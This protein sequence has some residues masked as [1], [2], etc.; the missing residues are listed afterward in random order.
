MNRLKFGF[1]RTK[2]TKTFSRCSIEISI[3]AFIGASLMLVALMMLMNC[4]DAF[5]RTDGIHALML[6]V[7]LEQTFVN[8]DTRPPVFV[9]NESRWTRAEGFVF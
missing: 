7:F 5:I 6:A 3:R 4:I 1:E 9:E 8:V 2:L